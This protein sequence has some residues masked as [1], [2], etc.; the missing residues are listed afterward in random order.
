MAKRVLIVDASTLAADN[1]KARLSPLADV[2]VVS[3]PAQVE[4]FGVGSNKETFVSK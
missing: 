2:T 4:S 1:L 3:D